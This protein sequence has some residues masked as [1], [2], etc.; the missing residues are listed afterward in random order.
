VEHWHCGV[1]MTETGRTEA[2]PR[3]N[4]ER[5]QAAI[6]GGDLGTWDLDLRTGIATH[7]ARHDQIWGYQEPQDEWGLEIAMKHV[8]P[9]DLPIITAAYER[10]L[11]TGVLSHENRIVWPDG[12]IHW[13]AVNGRVR[14]DGEG[15]PARVT[16]VVANVT[17][18]KVTEN[19]LRASENRFRAL[20]DSMP[21]LAWIADADGSISWYNGR[22]YEYTGT[23]PGDLEGWKWQDIHDPDQL[24]VVLERWSAS[25]ASGEAFEMT[26]PLRGAD[27]RYREFLTLASPVK[28]A[29]GRVVQWV[30][31]NTDVT[32]MIEVE[33]VLRETA[34]RIRLATA[35]T[36]VGIWE[37]DLATDQLRWDAEMFRIYGIEE[38]PG[39]IVPYS[40]WSN[41]VLPEDLAAQEAALRG[42]AP[43]GGESRREFRIRRADNGEVRQIQAVETRRADERGEIQAFV[44]TNLDVTDRKRSEE[45]LRHLAS[46]LSEAH[47]RKDEFLSTLAHE[48][49]NP[50]API[51]N[52]LEILKLARGTTGAGEGDTDQTHQMI[53]R[54][55]KQLVQ[56]VD[57][58]LDLSRISTGKLNLKLERVSLG[59]IFSTVVES[60]RATFEQM[61]Q[62]LV[63]TTPGSPIF[64]KADATRLVQAFLNLLNNASKYSD[65][66]ARISLAAQREGREVLVSVRDPGIGIPAH[67][68]ESIFEIFTQVDRSLEKSHGGLGIGLS[69]VKRLVALHGGSVEAHSD[70]PGRGSEFIVR[71]PVVL[72]PREEED[73]G[74]IAGDA[75]I[76]AV[77]C[78]I[79]VADDNE[80]AA[81]S[82]ATLLGM[83]GHDIR[84]ANDGAE[85]VEVAAEFKPQVILLDIGMPK[86]NG[87]DACRRVRAEPWG[88]D[89]LMIALTGWG[90][91]EDKRRSREA[92]FDHHLVKPVDTSLLIKL[93]ASCNPPVDK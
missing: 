82:L 34:E 35:A 18:R 27:G 36:G 90:Q 15:K 74:V 7:S 75:A 2:D 53:E 61:G 24:P 39:G 9:E 51:R 54:Q 48:L 43:P 4:E 57:D 52:G 1:R 50:L 84:T 5:L 88:Q 59:S 87:Y 20:A 49:R 89:A 28:D 19:L 66:G 67:M 91:E 6:E 30:G 38:A 44:G 26:F 60:S 42:E 37:W 71:L 14:Y 12:T 68:L 58:L 55:L 45:R 40:T 80:D 11:E 73:A 93:V 21:Q 70:G 78:R 83:F 13:I 72:P 77:R 65:R 85:A 22:W 3:E 47:R 23:S 16:G 79:L 10:A 17:D 62:E 46:E 25:M 56:L 29:R 31:T 86:L 69:L 76:S 81:T 32:S 33:T 64:V 92:G 63:V 41:A 8:L